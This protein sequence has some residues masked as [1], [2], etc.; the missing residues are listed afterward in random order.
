[1][2]RIGQSKTTMCANS[3]LQAAGPE[4]TI[5]VVALFF[6]SVMANHSNLDIIGLQSAIIDIRSNKKEIDNKSRKLIEKL[7]SISKTFEVTCELSSSI[8][9]DSIEFIRDRCVVTHYYI[10]L[11]K[12]SISDLERSLEDFV[13][14]V[15]HGK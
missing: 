12:R 5:P 15:N 7:A 14:H 1:M 8:E 10:S 6:K 13:E 2:A 4:S 11:L 3:N 9:V